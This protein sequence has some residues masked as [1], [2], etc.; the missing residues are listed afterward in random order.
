MITGNILSSA[1]VVDPTDPNQVALVTSLPAVAASVA[2]AITAGVLAYRTT[3]FVI[4]TIDSAVELGIDA[5]VSTSK[6]AANKVHTA[7]EQRK[8]ERLRESQKDEID[9]L[10]NELQM[11]AQMKAQTLEQQLVEAKKKERQMAAKIKELEESQFD[12]RFEVEPLAS[13]QEVVET[14]HSPLEVLKT[15]KK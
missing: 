9:R 1:L 12:Y 15:A 7:W 3:N 14:D 6:W 4:D 13:V 11:E 5:G 8:L 2:T 10:N